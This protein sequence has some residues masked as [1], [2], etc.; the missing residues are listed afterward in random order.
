MACTTILVG[1]KATY[2]GSTM[3]AR[4]S[5]SGSGRFT[6]KRMTVVQPAEQ[7]S[8][9]RSVLSHVEVP[10]P[11]DPMRCT[12]MPNALLDEGIWAGSGV[13]EANVGITA[14]ETITTN[15]RVQA[16]DPL[17][18]LRPAANGM[19]EQPGGIGEED[20]VT[21]V[22]PY[23]RSAREGVRRLGELH[24]KYGTYEMNAIAFQD[25]DEIWWFES[26]GGHHW[27][28]R[29]VPDDAYVVMPNQ[30]GIDQFD[31]EDALGE[32]REYMC[33]ADLR[34]FIAQNHLDLSLDGKLNPRDAFGS[35]SDSDHV[36]NT[37]RAW[38]IER[39][40]NPHACRWDGP[41][42]DC[43]PDADDIPWCRVPERRITAE[44][45]KY[46]LSS[47]Y[48]GTPYDPY[49]NSGDRSMRGKYRPIGINR[50]DFLAL[51]QIRPYM[52]AAWRSIHWIA[53]GSNAF[54]AMVPLYAGV[55]QIP[56]YFSKTGRDV[57]TDS[58]YWS[59][60]LI[61]A[62]ADGDYGSC[63]ALI[64]R[65]QMHV[66]SQ[67][68]AVIRNADLR[69]ASASPSDQAAIMEQANQEI[70]DMAAKETEDVLG[71]VLFQASMHMRNAYS[72]S[73]S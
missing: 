63:I 44:D 30:L 6:S 70:A 15:E 31:L 42:A 73:D 50:N 54:N 51:I 4:N 20:I 37:P 36:Y 52:P 2:D 53:F 64:E 27:I 22:L 11:A 61:G 41:D 67:G 69:L 72:R 60:R 7:G 46:V 21:L 29:R 48:Q 40:L 23:I 1:R 65:Y 58:F 10:L 47:Y 5:D 38:F 25:V 56:D 18:R 16:A 35:H 66:L 13:N 71:K 14:T 8:V 62:L 17:V 55:N 59:S 24:A 26:I 3:I 68:R 39:F 33:S 28:A 32:Q 57:S 19:P 43:R 49:A 9:Y 12:S 34:E 45:I